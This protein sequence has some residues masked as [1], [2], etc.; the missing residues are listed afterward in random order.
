M[1][2]TYTTSTS[3]G[4]LLV[5]LGYADGIPRA[6]TNVG[7]CSP[8]GGVPLQ[9]GWHGPVRPRRWGRAGIPWRRGDRRLAQAERGEPRLRPTGPGPGDT[10]GYDRHPDRTAGFSDCNPDR[11]EDRMVEF[12]RAGSLVAAGFAALAAGLVTGAVAERKFVATRWRSTPSRS[13]SWAGCV[14]RSARRASTESALRG[15]RHPE[16]FD[17]ERDDHD[18]QPWLPPEPPDLALPAAALRGQARLCSGTSGRMANPSGAPESHNIDQLGLDLD[19][20]IN[21]VA[22]V[23]PLV[24]V[25]HSMGGMTV[26]SLA[27]QSGPV[28]REVAGVGLLG[29]SSGGMAEVPRGCRRRSL[30]MAH[31]YAPRWCRP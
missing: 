3:T 28:L 10:I 13:P 9:A 18:L 8:L 11:G 14:V 2:H 16:G 31:R 17:P 20:V 19:A 1:G 27:A 29:T 25:G 24:L 15:R 23:G 12:R 21:H 30:G 22:P 7:P 5:P 4:Q 6:G 26:M